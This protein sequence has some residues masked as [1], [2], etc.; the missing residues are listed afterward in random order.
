M[1]NGGGNT[2]QCRNF[3]REF[4]RQVQ[5]QVQ[6]RIQDGRDATCTL[7]GKLQKKNFKTFKSK[8]RVYIVRA[9]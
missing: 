3:W 5:G 2:H 9:K 8:N 4:Q 1:K 6:G 7:S